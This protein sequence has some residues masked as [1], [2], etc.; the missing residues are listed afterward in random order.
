MPRLPICT[1]LSLLVLSLL[2]VIYATGWLMP[3]ARHL[4]GFVADDS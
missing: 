4:P 2:S 3:V 1:F